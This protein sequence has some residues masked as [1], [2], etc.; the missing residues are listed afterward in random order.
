MID[1]AIIYQNPIIQDNYYCA[2]VDEIIQEKEQYIYPKLLIKLKL[3]PIYEIP[4]Y[5]FYAIIHPSEN[6]YYHYKDFFVTYLH[7][8]HISIENIDQAL[9]RWGFVQI[10]K[11]RFGGQEYSAVKF[12]Y[13]PVP[14]RL[15]TLKLSRLQ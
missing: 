8:N 15:E 5:D 4:V 3:N 6:S 10:S 12:V 9:G 14:I 7:S 13:Q 1:N 11:S 2:R